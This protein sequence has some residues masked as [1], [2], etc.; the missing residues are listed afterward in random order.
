[1]KY[2]NLGFSG[3]KVSEISL[4]SWISFNDS[5]NID[6]PRAIINKA[7]DCGINLFDTSN[8]YHTGN[9]ESILG[10]VLS[11]HPRESYVISTKV[12]FPTGSGPNERG[13]SR[14]HIFSQVHKSLKRLK[15]DYIDIYFCHWYDNQTPI[16]E[17]LR[18]MNDLVCQGNILYYGVSNWTAAQI[19]D[20]L[21]TVDKFNLYPISVNQPSYNILDRYI[22]NETLPLCSKNG[23]G[24]IVYSPLAQGV[25]TGKYSLLKDY[26]TDSRAKNPLAKGAVSIFDYLNP[27]TLTT[28]NKIAEL[29]ESLKISLTELSLA[30]VLENSTISSAIIGASKPEQIEQNVKA[31]GLS[32]SEDTLTAIDKILSE[33]NHVI[34]HNI[35]PW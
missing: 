25:L 31:S 1:M 27:E 23:I 4:G 35:E 30:W 34:K 6:V 20:G 13:L 5:G 19:S 15:T 32:L 8:T 11:E 12:F 33:S 24:Q 17:S 28:V 18:A 10:E 14:K 3:L 9:A 7:F 26:P 21:R 16:E 22:E 29:A 2:R